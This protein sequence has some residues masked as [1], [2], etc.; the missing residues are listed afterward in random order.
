MFSNIGSKIKKLAK[1]VCWIG[2]VS[3]VLLAILTWA[4]GAVM[5][6]YSYGHR[7]DD[8]FLPGLLILLGGSFFSWI[9][10]FFTYGF[11]QLIE[12]SDYQ[13][14][15]LS[16]LERG[17]SAPEASGGSALTDQWV[18]KKCGRTNPKSRVSCKEC[19]EMH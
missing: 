15:V 13:A 5:N 11:G 4:G 8:T 19:G 17:G 18:C 6:S 9:G 3:S 2:I 1:V 10:A 7:S 14:Y 16:K 12:N